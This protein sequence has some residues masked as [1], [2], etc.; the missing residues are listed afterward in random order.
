M[1]HWAGP[2]VL[3]LGIL[4]GSGVAFVVPGGSSS[5]LL[6]GWNGVTPWGG[7][8][9]GAR[10]AAP[11]RGYTRVLLFWLCGFELALILWWAEVT[12]SGCETPGGVREG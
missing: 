7:F 9:G 5:G 1:R 3:I 8:L 10:V 4:G 6:A 11:S 2:W 12:E